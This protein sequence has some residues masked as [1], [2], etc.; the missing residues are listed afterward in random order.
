[1]SDGSNELRRG[2]T[3][4]A[5]PR[6]V[7]TRLAAWT[8]CAAGVHFALLS[9]SGHLRW[10]HY[11]LDGLLAAFAL[12][13]RRTE[14][15]LRAGLPLWIALFIY[16]DLQQL[17]FASLRG[18][19]HTGD[20]FLLDAL[21][22]P[23]PGAERMP[24][25]AWFATRTH[26]IVD[27]FA[28]IAYMGF[29]APFFGTLF[30]Y[31]LVEPDRAETMGWCF[32]AANAIAVTIYT[33]FPAAP[34]WYVLAHGL[35]P[36]DPAVLP[37]SAGAGRFDEMLGVGVFAGI[38]SMNPNVFGA[39][40]SLHAAYPLMAVWHLWHRGLFL[41]VFSV[42]FAVLV[43]FSAVYLSHHYVIDVLAG[44]ATAFLACAAGQAIAH[45]LTRARRR[46]QAA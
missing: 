13:G 29:V 35:G 20:I 2:D 36:A 45:R 39:M 9:A 23:S 12:G 32:L 8:L 34:P 21:L 5:A 27:L 25:A 30:V 10:E 18:E 14:G 43:A 24:W 16:L 22:F 3:A 40:P 1:M 11:V 31:V 38:Y 17:A 41:R 37:D 28:G 15:L 26:P 33:V 19:I 42:S 7:R 6:P 46:A 4:G 44:I